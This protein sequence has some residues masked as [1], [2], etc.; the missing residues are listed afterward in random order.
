VGPVCVIDL[1]SR[2]LNEALSEMMRAEGMAPAQ[3]GAVWSA[4][5]RRVADV[6]DR[7][8]IDQENAY[9]RERGFDDT[10]PH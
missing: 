3:V 2:P 4:V 7:T 6:S 1:S 9:N 8:A 5:Q 10:R